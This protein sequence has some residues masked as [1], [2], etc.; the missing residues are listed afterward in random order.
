MVSLGNKSINQ[1]YSSVTNRISYIS[2]RIVILAVIIKS[3]I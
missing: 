2:V 3:I 1:S